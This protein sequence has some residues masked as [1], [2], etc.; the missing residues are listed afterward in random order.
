ML[1]SYIRQTRR[2]LSPKNRIQMEFTRKVGVL[3]GY[4]DAEGYIRI[5]YS[6]VNTQSG[7]TF[8][9]ETGIEL[10]KKNTTCILTPE[11]IAKMP[12]KVRYAMPAFITRCEKYFKRNVIK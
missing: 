8:D 3:I 1:I 2:E 5:G 7:D 9:R 12:M 6:A 11:Q 10:A 4:L